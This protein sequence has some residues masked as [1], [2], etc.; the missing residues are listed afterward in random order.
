MDVDSVIQAATA[1]LVPLGTL[2]GV[3]S[4]RRRLR[5]E[6]RENLSLIKELEQNKVIS[7]HSPA[8]AWLHGRVAI[9]VARLAGQRLGVAKKP[10]P[11]GS[12]SLAGVLALVFGW[13]TWYLDRD[14]FVWYSVFP[15]V[16]AFLM[17]V[18]VI[19]MIAN[20]EQ[21]VD[22]ELPEGAVP[23]Q[24][25]GLE[26]VAAPVVL[27]ATGAVDSRFDPDMQVGVSYRFL[28]AMREGLYE[29]GLEL[30]DRNWLYCRVQS[31][32]W[33]NRSE[34]GEDVERLDS[35]AD[36]MVERRDPVELWTDF[37][38]IES[39][40]F[41]EVWGPID[42]DNYGAASKRRRISEDYDVVVLAPLGS[43]GGYYVET[44]T[45]LRNALVFVLHN[46]NGKW[47]I[48]NHIGN[49]PPTPGW[50]PAWWDTQVL[51]E[52]E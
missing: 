5:H 29:D 44:A 28:R 46:D 18:S 40:R 50:P 19:G 52:G 6:V 38:A 11:W 20:R 17:L 16:V 31:W 34:F 35:L 15:G 41:V 49:A 8:V 37:I 4:R 32:L 47:L 21:A 23:V 13:W 45:Q 1:I 27:A 48:S 9:D 7:H 25:E 33:N 39:A 36:S 22:P 26:Q 12:V 10:I 30:A 3:G 43:S 42:P 14:Q 2:I 51:E 24:A